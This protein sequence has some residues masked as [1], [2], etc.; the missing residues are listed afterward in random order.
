MSHQTP[1]SDTPAITHSITALIAQLY[2]GS[3]LIYTN[4]SCT[5]YTFQLPPASPSSDPPHHHR[6]L[7]LFTAHASTSY[8]SESNFL[9]A[10]ASNP[11]IPSFELLAL[12]TP[13][14]QEP[15]NGILYSYAGVS[16]SNLSQS[17]TIKWPPSILQSLLRNA[18]EGLQTLHSH[19]WTHSNI[20]ETTVC[21]YPNLEDPVSVKFISFFKARQSAGR[22]VKERDLKEFANVWAGVLDKM[23][24]SDENELKFSKALVGRMVE[25]AAGYTSASQVLKMLD[26][27]EA[28]LGKRM[29][30]LSATDLGGNNEND[31]DGETLP[32]KKSKG[33]QSLFERSFEALKEDFDKDPSL[34]T[35]P[36]F[37]DSNIRIA[38]LFP[39]FGYARCLQVIQSQAAP[40]GFETVE[41]LDAYFDEKETEYRKMFVQDRENQVLDNDLLFLEPLYTTSGSTAGQITK[42]EL[43]ETE[44]SSL[45]FLFN[46]N[47][48]KIPNGQ[49]LVAPTLQTFKQN[50][51]AFTCGMFKYVD[52]S[53]VFVA[54]GAVLSCLQPTKVGEESFFNSDV[55]VFLYGLELGQVEGK[56]V[57]IYEAVMKAVSGDPNFVAEMALQS[58]GTGHRRRRGTK[59]SEDK[60]LMIV[61]NLRSLT[62]VGDYPRRQIQIVF[63]LFKSPAEVLMGFDIDACCFGYNGSN[64]FAL[65]RALRALTRSYNLVDMTRRS[66]SYEH[67]LYKY[68][69]RN[70]AI[71]IPKSQVDFTKVIK[72][73]VVRSP[74]GLAKLINLETKG[75]VPP[76]YKKT[77]ESDLN[78]QCKGELIQLDRLTEI[79]QNASIGREEGGGDMSH[80]Q[81]VKIPY[82]EKWPLE[83]LYGFAQ[84]FVNTVGMARYYGPLEYIRRIENA[85][86][87]D[88]DDDDGDADI[89]DRLEDLSL[90]PLIVTLNDIFPCLNGKVPQF[91]DG[92]DRVKLYSFE[93][94]WVTQNPGMQM[95]SG[96]FEPV[97][98]SW[99]EWVKDACDAN[100]RIVA[101]G[102][103]DYEEEYEEDE[104]EDD[105]MDEDE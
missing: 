70:F 33:G 64:V 4:R 35:N 84:G 18:L 47:L 74:K 21:V 68:T 102:E 9:Q 93:D 80:Y 60:K 66:A 30:A 29:Q 67:R 76:F 28:G 2:P 61:R 17:A 27:Y 56:V 42:T 58:G 94:S 73:R 57:E 77:F 15:I 16:L 48:T 11:C 75:L 63:R 53:N 1:A 62:L 96:S 89:S 99:E 45:E 54:G 50:W 20:L 22:H 19:A 65:P 69:K 104:E 44:T 87:T 51:D 100:A 83:R 24:G 6:F 103:D 40:D 55:D 38:S 95:L 23:G 39:Q 97:E 71:A 7:K 31:D 49:E 52:F 59:F 90:E 105:E 14:S 5:Q 86:G 13:T 85:S 8:T 36:A 34:Y 91:L 43:A 37:W 101:V 72:G 88:D 32:T 10:N 82:G 26:R 46:E 78:Q 79:L 12:Q 3:Q 92:G 98:T 25:G 81:V 41:Q